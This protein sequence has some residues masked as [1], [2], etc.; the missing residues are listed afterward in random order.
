MHCTLIT[1]VLLDQLL[2]YFTYQFFAKPTFTGKTSSRTGDKETEWEE[3]RV[4]S[5]LSFLSARTF[6]A[7]P[8]LLGGGE[9]L[10][11]C[12][13]LTLGSQEQQGLQYLVR[14]CVRL[15]VCYHVFCAYIRRA[16]RQQNSDTKGFIAT[17]ASF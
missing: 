7:E 17:L 5:A 2:T 14:K 12:L 10:V 6:L 16:P 3:V 11:N 8:H 15:S 13:L 9:G 4:T 1:L